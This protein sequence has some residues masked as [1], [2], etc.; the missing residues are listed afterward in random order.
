MFFN[1]S[2]CP[3]N[4][5]VYHTDDTV[6]VLATI[7]VDKICVDTSNLISVSKWQ[8]SNI[9]KGKH[10]DS[11][12]QVTLGFYRITGGLEEKNLI[13]C[14]FVGMQKFDNKM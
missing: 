12:T 7:I 13:L 11:T 6:M 3:F 1:F 10:V 14:D 5:S 4:A 9:W 8:T 2:T